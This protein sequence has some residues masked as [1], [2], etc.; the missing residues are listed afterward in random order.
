MM[1]TTLIGNPY[2][3]CADRDVICVTTNGALKKDGN[4]IMTQGWGKFVRETFENIDAKLGKYLKTYGNRVFNLGT[5][6]YRGKPIIVVS[7]PTKN[8]WMGQSDLG[9]IKKSAQELIALCNKFNLRKV[10]VPVPNGSKGKLKWSEV[11][12]ALS[13]LDDRFVVYSTDPKTF[14]A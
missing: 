1:F 8:D 4:A 12:A 5:Q 14:D 6:H 3:T 13:E 2:D 7:F 9:L 11:K 10:Y